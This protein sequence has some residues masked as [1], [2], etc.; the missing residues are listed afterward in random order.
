MVPMWEC[1]AG[2]WRSHAR[3]IIVRS[4]R[5]SWINTEYR[6]CD[7]ITAGQMQKSFRRSTCRTLST[8]SCMRWARS[9]SEEHTS[10]LQSRGHLVC[11]LLL[12][13]KNQNAIDKQESEYEYKN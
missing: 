1:P 6:Y 8:K 3:T 10:E 7:S 2:E 11:R 9:R 12:E 5:M 13:K 4:I